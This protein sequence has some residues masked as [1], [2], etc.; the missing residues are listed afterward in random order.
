MN[1]RQFFNP[2]QLAQAVGQAAAA[3]DDAAETAPVDDVALL[4]FGRRAM[5]TQFEVILP[6]GIPDAQQR[7]EAALNEVHRLED[8]LTVYHDHSEISRLNRRAASGDVRVEDRLFRLLQLA[9]RLHQE[10]AGAFD[11]TTG[12]LTKTW[13]FFKRQGRVPAAEEIRSAL[14]RVGSRHLVLDAERQSVRFLRSGLEI[15]LGSIGKGYALDRVADVLRHGGVEVGLLHGGHSSVC[16]LG[17]MPGNARGWA[18]GVKHPW[19]DER[20]AVVRL[21]GRSL[22]TSAAT[23][24]HL[25]YNGKKLGH[26]LDPRTGL[27]ATGIASATVVAPTAAEADALATAFFILGVEAAQAYCQA[28]PGIGAL[29]LSDSDDARLVVCGLAPQDVELTTAE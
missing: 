12:A 1:R 24:Q 11:I 6:F 28:H 21:R 16:A 4:R 7:A 15:N 2:Q 9:V 27:P 13:G 3:L 25:E 23:F 14:E 19:R 10:T 18:V 29:L 20:L 8:Q 5:A 22:G 17:V 26:I